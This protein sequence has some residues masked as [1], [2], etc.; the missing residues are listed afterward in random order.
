MRRGKARVVRVS[1]K[2]PC[3]ALAVIVERSNQGPFLPQYTLLLLLIATLSNSQMQAQLQMEVRTPG[4]TSP[5]QSRPIVRDTCL[6]TFRGLSFYYRQIS[7]HPSSWETDC[8]LCSFLIIL[9][10]LNPQHVLGL[11][12][13]KL[14][15][16]CMDGFVPCLFC[17]NFHT[18]GNKIFYNFGLLVREISNCKDFLFSFAQFI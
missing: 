1:I 2:R 5:R 4:F 12:V 7:S 8:S 16:E 6:R 14:I 13:R 15:F 10:I 18:I 3:L 17:L 9:I 11:N